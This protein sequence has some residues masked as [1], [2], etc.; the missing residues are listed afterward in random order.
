MK[1]TAYIDLSGDSS[2]LDFAVKSLCGIPVITRLL[3]DLEAA[4]IQRVVIRIDDAAAAALTSVV[5]K[6]GRVGGPVEWTSAPLPDLPEP[7]L[8]LDSVGLLEGPGGRFLAIRTAGDFATAGKTL[9]ST[10]RKPIEDDGFVCYY[11]SRHISLAITRLLL[12]LPITPNQATVVAFLLG[13][14]G[15][16]CVAMGQWGWM[17]LGAALYQASTIFDNVDGE[18]ARLKRIFSPIGEWLDTLSDDLTNMFFMAGMGIGLARYAGSDVYLY[19]GIFMFVEL[20]LYNGVIYHYLL[21]RTKSGNVM[22]YKWWFDIG[23]TAEMQP[24]RSRVESVA[25]AI[26]YLGRRDFFIAFILFCA[27]ANILVAAFWFMV[28]GTAVNLAMLVLQLTVHRK[29]V[30]GGGLP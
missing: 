30:Y 25:S 19:A 5:E 2:G 29:K 11:V 14:A 21:T 4:G 23:Q 10:I 15:A 13:C 8:L 24:A 17:A 7:P 12:P 1:P 6:D 20:A 27:L 28:F 9:L 18:I 3:M 16:V 22:L 26:K